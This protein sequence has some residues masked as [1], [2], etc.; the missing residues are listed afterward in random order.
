MI[1]AEINDKRILVAK[2]PDKAEHLPDIR[3]DLRQFITIVAKYVHMDFY[4]PIQQQSTSIKWIYK[5]IRDSMKDT[6]F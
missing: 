2:E 1:D 4:N 5:K 3:R 6:L